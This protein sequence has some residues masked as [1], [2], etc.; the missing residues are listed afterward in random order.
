MVIC[1][2]VM[3]PESGRRG[4][5]LVWVSA[6]IEP[7][8]LGCPAG[9]APWSAGCGS[10]GAKWCFVR[11]LQFD[12]NLEELAHGVRPGHADILVL[13]HEEIAIPRLRMYPPKFM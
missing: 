11:C 13:E 4:K 1:Y 9:G 7:K 2:G 8:S 5:L 12:Q 6:K 3:L 10:C